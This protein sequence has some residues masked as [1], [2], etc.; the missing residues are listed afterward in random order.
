MSETVTDRYGTEAPARLDGVDLLDAEEC[1]NCGDDSNP[2][3]QRPAGYYTCPTCWSTWA[4]DRTDADLV[5]Y[6]PYDGEGGSAD[7]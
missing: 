3:I 7:E 5:D 4:G 2:W 1:P 6:C